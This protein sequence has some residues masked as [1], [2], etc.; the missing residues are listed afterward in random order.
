MNDLI[1]RKIGMATQLRRFRFQPLRSLKG[2]QRG[3][4]AR[5]KRS[6]AVAWI[7][8]G[9]SARGHRQAALN[10]GA[11]VSAAGLR[12]GG[13]ASHQG[14]VQITEAAIRYRLGPGRT[15]AARAADRL[16]R[17]RLLAAIRITTSSDRS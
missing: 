12:G 1:Y 11:K 17:K 3:F 13:A 7:A 10:G 6:C 8:A 9:S 15:A 16:P 5:S 14:E 2:T 4:T